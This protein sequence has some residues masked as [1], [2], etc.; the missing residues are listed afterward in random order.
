MQGLHLPIARVEVFG[1]A[2]PLVGP[3]FKNAYITKTAQKARWCG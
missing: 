3:G 2:I 1:V